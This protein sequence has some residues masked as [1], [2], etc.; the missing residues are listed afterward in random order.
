MDNVRKVGVVALV[1][2]LMVVLGVLRPAGD[3]PRAEASLARPGRHCGAAVGGAGCAGTEQPEYP[4]HHRDR[5]AGH[6]GRVLLSR[7]DAFLSRV[8]TGPCPDVDGSDTI[9]PREP[10]YGAI[11]FEMTRL[12]PQNSGPP[13]LTFDANGDHTLVVSDNSGADMD[14]RCGRG[15]GAR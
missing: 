5:A 9:G 2:A 6:R 14:C 10:P 8:D 7:R 13:A 4:G 11:T 1:A 15:D 12:Y 3:T